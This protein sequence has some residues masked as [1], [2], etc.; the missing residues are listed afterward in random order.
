MKLLDLEFTSDELLYKIGLNTMEYLIPHD[1]MFKYVHAFAI[2]SCSV[3]NTDGKKALPLDDI[4]TQY[5]RPTIKYDNGFADSYQIDVKLYD[6]NGTLRTGPS[7]PSGYT[8]SQVITMPLGVG[9]AEL[10]GWGYEKAGYWK[11]GD[12][13]YEFYHNGDLIY[14]HEFSIPECAPFT[15][16]ACS[17]A[18]TDGNGNKLPFGASYTQYLQPSIKFTNA[19]P[20]TY[21][22]DVRLYD[23]FPYGYNRSSNS[24]QNYTYS[25]KVTLSSKNGNVIVGQWGNNHSGNWSAGEYTYEFFYKGKLLYNYYF[26]IPEYSYEYVDLGLPS[27]TLW[28]TC[29]VGAKTPWD[30][31]NF[32]AWGEIT[33][34]SRYGENNYKFSNA[35]F[36]KLTKYCID[37][38]YGFNGLRDNLSVLQK[39][40]D[41]ATEK[42]GSEWRMPTSKEFQELIDYCTWRWTSNYEG[43]YVSGFIVK[44]R[45]YSDRHIFFPAAGGKIPKGLVFSEYD[46]TKRGFYWSGNLLQSYFSGTSLDAVCLTFEP[47][48]MEVVSVPRYFGLSVRAVRRK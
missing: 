10:P 27:G 16:T 8:Y 46:D 13:R 21:Q 48:Y 34:K 29:N 18:N 9:R 42:M 37:L 11:A 3:S 12:Y 36:T 45:K 39:S 23:D 32:F 24:P 38:E 5:L 35:N 17:V 33:T 26:S 4:H 19:V 6:S 25:Y 41:V 20:G 7:S 2:T 44:S 31:G 30:Y 1:D 15:I 47:N 22:I 14:T 43:H 40:D 28:C